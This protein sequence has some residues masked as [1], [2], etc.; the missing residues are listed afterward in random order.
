MLSDQRA[1]DTV[2]KVLGVKSETD[3][4]KTRAAQMLGESAN[5]KAIPVLAKAFDANERNTNVASV[6]AREL[7]KFNDKAALKELDRIIRSRVDRFDDLE[8]C[9]IACAGIVASGRL[10][11][12]ETIDMLIGLLGPIWAKRPPKGRQLT[13]DDQVAEDQRNSIEEALVNALKEI[14]GQELSAYDEWKAW[15]D[16]NKKTWQPQ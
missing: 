12:T 7:G 4:V 3:S 14:T 5:P 9:S 13:G 1:L 10:R 16:A 8:G 6:I 15:W 2:A 11:F